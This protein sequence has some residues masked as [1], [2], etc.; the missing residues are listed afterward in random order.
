MSSCLLHLHAHRI[1]ALLQDRLKMIL[2]QSHQLEFDQILLDLALDDTP[3]R[4]NR[5]EFRAVRRQEHE[6]E[7]EIPRQLCDVLGVMRW[8][9]V[10]YNEHF[11]IGVHELLA[12]DGQKLHHMLLVSCWGLHEDRHLKTGADGAEDSHTRPTE[13]GVGPFHCAVGSSP[14]A[15]APHPHVER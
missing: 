2:C 8:V 9:V 1:K 13:L 14:S 11:F 6:D 3:K 10:Q 7:V 4:F 15:C 5:I 12:K